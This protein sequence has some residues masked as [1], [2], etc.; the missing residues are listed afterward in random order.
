MRKRKDTV[1]AVGQP[2]RDA[3]TPVETGVEPGILGPT[4]ER[5]RESE[6]DRDE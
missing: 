4:S 3:E 5:A 2:V 1:E 6:G